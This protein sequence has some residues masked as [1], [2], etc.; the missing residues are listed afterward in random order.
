MYILSP[1]VFNYIAHVGN[2]SFT[3]IWRPK[4]MYSFKSLVVSKF[5][6]NRYVLKQ[7]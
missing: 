3:D 5:L 7:I 4:F 2:I 6:S 1:S